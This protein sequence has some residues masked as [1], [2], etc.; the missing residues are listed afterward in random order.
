[1]QTGTTAQHAHAHAPQ[2]QQTARAAR[3]AHTRDTCGPAQKTELHDLASATTEQ[4]RACAACSSRVASA[5][6]Y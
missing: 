5:F 6:F 4:R 2:Q 1:M 3:A